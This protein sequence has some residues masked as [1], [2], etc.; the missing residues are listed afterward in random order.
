MLGENSKCKTNEILH[1]RGPAAALSCPVHHTL[2]PSLPPIFGRIVEFGEKHHLEV[3]LSTS[4]SFSAVAKML[5]TPSRTTPTVLS[6]LA[7]SRSQKGLRTPSPHKWT[8]W[9]T[10]A[11]NK[12]FERW[13][14][15]QATQVAIT[16]PPLVKFV[17]AHAA[18]F[19]ALKSP[20][21]F[22][23]QKSLGFSKDLN[24][25]HIHRPWWGCRWGAAALQHP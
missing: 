2:P 11:K 16:V 24:F 15:K 4:E 18:S 20:W 8:I 6:S 25:I 10:C 9:G 1:S 3:T 22:F 19:W 7:A 5:L 23:Y 17:I 14:F 13:V 12:E 21:S